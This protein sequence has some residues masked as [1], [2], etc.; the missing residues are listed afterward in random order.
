MLI[1][2]K[3]ILDAE[4]LDN[5]RSLLDKAQFVD[6]IL[7]AGENA[8]R[9]KHNEELSINQKQRDYLDQLLIGNLAR[10]EHFRSAALP[11]QVSQPV[12]ARY[13]EGM[14][15]GNHIDDPIMG[16]AGGRFRVD[17]AVT[18]FLSAPESYDGGELVVNTTFGDTRVKLPAGDAVLYPASSLH[19]VDP[20]TSGQRLV[21]VC[22]LQSLVRDPARRELLYE[23]DQAR[24]SLRNTLPDSVEASQ[25]DH[26]YTNLV[27][28]W[29]E[30]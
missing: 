7:S 11:H 19:R 23:L 3:N 28:M 18:L 22:W 2:L 17:V 20:V 5:I 21:M 12:F 13:S 14:E 25:V 27:R 8:Q 6:G 15:Y 10:N 30:I 24:Q 4:L 9:V 1:T 29:S 16:G 26:T